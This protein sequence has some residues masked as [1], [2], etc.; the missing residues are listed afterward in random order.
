MRIN[1]RGVVVSHEK[2]FI[3]ERTSGT[4][5]SFSNIENFEKYAI[6]WNFTFI[7]RA[8]CV[9]YVCATHF[10]LFVRQHVGNTGDW[11]KISWWC[12]QKAQNPG[13]FGEKIPQIPE[14]SHFH[15]LFHVPY[16]CAPKLIF[17]WQAFTMYL[18]KAAK[19]LNSSAINPHT[20]TKIR[21][22]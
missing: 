13:H 21:K 17:S 11:D 18:S 15:S 16:G 19:F 7:V 6:F 14:F 3:V 2:I 12:T 8:I 1:F 9:P 4:Y 22:N 20:L 10:F 5:M